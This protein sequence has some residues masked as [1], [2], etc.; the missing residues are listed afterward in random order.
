MKQM[1]L[2]ADDFGQNNDISLGILQLLPA[3]RL[4]AV[5]CLT[6][7]PA[8]QQ[9]AKGLMSYSKVTDIGLHFNLT[10]GSSKLSSL[11]KL[12]VMAHLRQLDKAK[13]RSE[14]ERQLAAFTEQTGSLPDFI[15]GHQHIQHLPII[16]EVIFEWY[17]SLGPLQ[18][19]YMRRS[20]SSFSHILKQSWALPKAYI[21]G[22]TG[23]ISFGA[24]LNRLGIPHNS[25]F[26]G[27]YDFKNA[28]RYAEIFRKILRVLEQQSLVMCHP[29]LTSV[30]YSDDLHKSREHEF[31]YFMSD[32][33]SADCRE[34]GVELVRF[35][36]NV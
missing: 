16:R 1:I 25:S 9:Y 5:S 4:T 12:I 36:D 24:K 8:W 19:P 6:T 21:I 14:L 26:S 31:K 33:F 17:K 32:L 28:S 3:N 30:D 2:C 23:G 13:I 27:V 7:F 35:G 22:L 10:A 18:L 20:Y 11:P 34:A 15:D 29:G